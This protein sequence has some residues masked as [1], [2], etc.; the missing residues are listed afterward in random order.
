MCGPVLIIFF[1][2]LSC[3]SVKDHTISHHCLKIREPK[4]VRYT[5]IDLPVF[6]TFGSK[7]SEIADISFAVHFQNETLFGLIAS[8]PYILDTKI[9]FR[10]S[11]QTGQNLKSK[12]PIIKRPHEIS[13]KRLGFPSK[14]GA[15]PRN[16]APIAMQ[17]V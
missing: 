8:I 12:A 11:L 2:L 1:A 7:D 6:V 4:R 16:A 3:L 15:A 13:R 14:L 5:G 10:L 17:M 9:H